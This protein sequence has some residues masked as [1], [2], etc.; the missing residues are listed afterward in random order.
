[1][2]NILITSKCDDRH[3][4]KTHIIVKLICTYL[5]RSAR[6]LIWKRKEQN[7]LTTI[8]SFNSGLSVLNFDAKSITLILSI[9]IFCNIQVMNSQIYIYIYYVY[10]K[11]ENL[12]E[13]IVNRYISDIKWYRNEEYLYLIFTLIIKVCVIKNT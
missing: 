3:Q 1:M 11:R 7:Y 13:K 6:N 4:R 10:I 9:K 12:L 8:F 5:H 2:L